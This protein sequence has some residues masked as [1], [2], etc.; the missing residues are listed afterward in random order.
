MQDLCRG[1]AWLADPGACPGHLAN[2]KGSQIFC[3]LGSR[4]ELTHQPQLPPLY[5]KDSPLQNV[6]LC[7]PPCDSGLQQVCAKRVPGLDAGER[8]RV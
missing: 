7:L 3:L 1:G 6:T 8:G 4:A 2:K 5:N